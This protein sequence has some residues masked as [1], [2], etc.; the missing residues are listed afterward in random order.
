ML[1]CAVLHRLMS[2]VTACLLVTTHGWCYHRTSS[3][4]QRRRQP[5]PDLD[6]LLLLLLLAAAVGL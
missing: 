6:L 5:L 3:H 1:C 2:I 4:Q